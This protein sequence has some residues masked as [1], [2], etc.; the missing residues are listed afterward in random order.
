[1]RFLT[2]FLAGLF[3]SFAA[4]AEDFQTYMRG[5]EQRAI[6]SGVSAN[7]VHRALQDVTLERSAISNDRN[8]PETHMTLSEYVDKTIRPQRIDRGRA[9]YLKYQDILG[10]IEEKYGVP[11]T[12][13]LALWGKETDFGGFSGDSETISSLATM[14]YEGRRRA[15]FEQELL[16]AIVLLDYLKIPPSEMRGSWAG[17]I[18]QCQF[19]P[20][21][22][23]K[24][25]VDGNQNG[26]VDLW[27]EMPDV[28]ASMAN[29][30][31]KN[32][33]QRGQGWGQSVSLP[34]K[35]DKNLIGRDKDP[36][37]FRF[38]EQHGVHFKQS[39]PS[40]VASDIRIYQ[41]DE[42][43]P[44]YGLYP[45]FDV[46]VNWNHSGYFAISIGRLAEQVS[47]H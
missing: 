47:Q 46:L 28:F 12:V 19:M 9:N 43:G 7:A 25:G 34:S 40:S 15:F 29:M 6:A 35:F 3:F 16:N 14:A 4:H 41:P 38:W 45:N 30:L 36:R 2:I 23:L 20:S 27:H 5:Y 21:S 1:M 32:G 33:W 26:R 18:G 22:Y 37:T 31:V 10:D 17:A 42:G 11:G 13:I 39:V 24:Y 8:Q 44:A